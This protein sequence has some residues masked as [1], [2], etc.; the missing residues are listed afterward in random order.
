MVGAWPWVKRKVK[1]NMRLWDIVFF[2]ICFGDVG[3]LQHVTP[4]LVFV[5]G[6]GMGLGYFS[7][8]LDC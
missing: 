1:R 4:P 7:L 2:S 6:W 5:P 8:T 3:K